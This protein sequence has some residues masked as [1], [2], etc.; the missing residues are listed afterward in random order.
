MQGEWAAGGA[1]TDR[2]D[3]LTNVG[4]VYCDAAGGG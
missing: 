4:A 2:R 3:G 1:S